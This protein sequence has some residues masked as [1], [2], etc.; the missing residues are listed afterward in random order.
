MKRVQIAPR[1]GYQSRLEEAGLSFHSWDNYWSESVAYEFTL[2]QVETIEA[3]AEE[4]HGMAITALKHVIANRQLGRL[5]IDAL[6]HGA[7]ESSF[8]RGD[9][10]LYGRFDLRYDGVNPPKLLE[11]NY[12]TPTSILETAVCGWQWMEDVFPM[13]D[14]FN[15]LHE[16]L[17]E[18]WKRL[19]QGPI[20]VATLRGNEEDWVSG[21]Y[22]VDTLTQ[23]G[24]TGHHIVIEEI[25]YDT[26][27]K[28]FMDR[29]GRDIETVFALYPWEWMF[30][31]AFGPYI[32]GS[33]TRFIEPMWKA[34]LSSKAILPVMWELFPGHPNLLPAYFEAGKLT[35][36][37]RK[38]I[39]SREG[40]NVTLVQD[41]RVIAADDGPYGAEGY[42]E[43]ELC[44][45]P[46][47]DGHHPVIGAWIVGDQP[48]G[49]TVRE[50]P[51][52]I[53]T[54]MSN[55]VQHYFI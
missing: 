15:S 48:A 37:A 36:F 55:I 35:S 46:E 23:A 49:M 45:L 10:S 50:S 29:S 12:D 32:A 30:A 20:H 2:T 31:E 8:D 6:Y 1:A 24:H 22:L 9:F 19:P 39:Y 33:R 7:I 43:Q 11:L 4:L 16:K 5:G 53:T 38:P 25:D 52:P 54:N 13:A 21:A 34:P 42:V 17:I 3:A 51:N 40:A 41:G 14:Q 47:F 18:Q 26:E 44:L 27:R 28:I